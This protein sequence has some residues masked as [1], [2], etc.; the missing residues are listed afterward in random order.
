MD[1]STIPVDV[2][3]L[4]R[5]YNYEIEVSK[6]KQRVM[7]QLTDG[8]YRFR[9]RNGDVFILVS[10]QKDNSTTSEYFR[11]TLQWCP[12]CHKRIGTVDSRHWDYIMPHHFCLCGSRIRRY[13]RHWNF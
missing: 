9:E 7:K 3:R 2:L 4:I 10:N 11:R 5:E 12:L 8:Y 13:M 1:F 6:R